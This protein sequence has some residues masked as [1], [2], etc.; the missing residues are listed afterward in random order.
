M[1]QIIASTYE[2]IKQIGSGGGGIVYLGRHLRLGKW[3]V[4]KA[5]RRTISAKPETLRREVD[6]LKNLSHT[7]IPQ[8]Y[9][10]VV[11]GETVYTVMD[12]IEGESLDK[13]LR[14]G[15]RFS[16]A[17]VIQWAMEL[18]EALCY[19]H[20]RPPHGILHSDIKPSNIMRT[21]QNDICLI[22]FNIALALG[23]E[24]AVRVG[25]SRGYASPEHY[26]VD[27]S[28]MNSTQRGE[29]DVLTRVSTERPETV[30]SGASSQSGSTSTERR[31]VLLDVRSDIYSLGATLYHLF[32]G[33]RPAQ[34]AK[35]VEPIGP[36]EL[37]PAVA[38]IIRKAMDPDPGRRWQTAQE[39]L[40]AFEHL[41]DNDPR[42][43]RHKRRCAVT[44]AVLTV[45]FLAGGL[46]AFTGLK[47]QERLQNAYTL[48]EYSANALAQGDVDQAVAYALEALPQDPG[49][50]GPPQT[51]QAQKA[52]TDALGVYDLSDGFKA[53]C[54][55]SVPGEPIKVALSPEGTRAAVLTSGQVTVFDCESGSQLAA[56]PAETSAL[57][58]L[59]FADEDTLLYAGDGALRCF[60]LAAGKERWAGKAATAI[61]LS[62]D[63]TAVAAVYKDE[64]VAAV[65]DVATGTAERAVTFGEKHQAVLPN[66]VFAD[67]E[68]NLLALDETGQWLAAS[69][70]DGSLAVFSLQ[71]SENDLVLFDT[72]DYTHFE[73]GFQGQYFAFSATS[74]TESVFAVIDLEN[75]A[76]TGGFAGARPFHVQA[77]ESGIYV[78]TDNILVR[79]HPVT[80]EQTEV[81]YTDADI[82]SFARSG[83][84]TLTA[85]DDG[86]CTIFDS[87]ARRIQTR[88]EGGPWDF[89]QVAGDFAMTASRDRQSVELLRL[90][91]H[92]EAQLA[93]YDPDYSHNEARISADGATVMLFRY[94]AFRICGMD[95]S[96]VADVEVPDAEQV[97]DQQFRREG[98]ESWLE[99]IYNDGT[100][101]R[102][103]AADGTLLSEEQGAEPDRTLYEEFFTDH[104][105]I[106]SPL[107][108]TPVAY[109]RETGELVRELEPDAYLTY[110]TQVGDYV[111]TEYISAQ[112]QRYGLL[113]DGQCR[114]L[115]ELPDLCD[116][117][118]DGTLV[119]D[120]MRGNLRQCRIYSMQELLT[121]ADQR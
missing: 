34:D 46:A 57:A 89:V 74:D 9:D 19:L 40:Q 14:R 71:D 112:G 33:R 7:Y 37:S 15:E 48:A 62:A 108:G 98:Q 53:H 4:L 39:M 26:G 41:H 105:K 70:S 84:Y 56:L 63:G 114:T 21:P 106:T 68:D 61:S 35:K 83:A 86:C 65:Y 100:I 118:A 78:C 79:L 32:T 3:V 77:D 94:D 102:Y 95:G 51:P 96:V 42:M 90:E 82:S 52:L 93:A 67:P 119:F 75:M 121:L 2:I 31:T 88:T 30:L 59:V 6:A 45:T 36:D 66:D 107:H 27:Y 43:R 115:A 17:Q 64:N 11:E 103:S 109:D 20:S 73:G 10:F 110:V 99:V 113:L 116:I 76:Q 44:A 60:D 117:L 24:G 13:P 69:F 50:F 111:V 28:G 85:T 49:I 5:D 23:E 120:D 58:D 91:N 97:Y 81:A 25:F 12:Y 8:V 18:L 104:L 72:S 38:A 16:Q 54:L 1:S 101:R 29:D 22:D 47:Q 92:P 80:G 55:L 87:G